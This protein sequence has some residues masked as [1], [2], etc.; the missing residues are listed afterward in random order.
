MVYENE[1]FDD[2]EIGDRRVGYIKK[3]REDGLVDAALQPQGYRAASGSA[4][5]MVLE[6]LTDADGFLPLHDKSS[7][8]DIRDMLGMSKKAFK[9][10]IGGLYKA[11]VIRIT[12]KG[13]ELK[14]EE[15]DGNK[16]GRK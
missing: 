14:R 12:P 16:G 5:E 3:V 9:M 10:A 6:V 11:G 8:D 4:Q 15:N 2:F 7:P 13:I 1:V